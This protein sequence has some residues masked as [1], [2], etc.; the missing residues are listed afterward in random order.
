MKLV[1]TTITN[2]RADVIGKMLAAIAPHVDECIVIDTGADEATRINADVAVATAGGRITWRQ[3]RWR[4]DFAAARNHALTCAVAADADWVIQADTDEVYDFGNVAPRDFLAQAAAKGVDAV[5]V[6]H[7]SRMFGQ[8]RCLRVIPGKLPRWKMPVHEWLD[9][10]QVG[11]NAPDCWSWATQER[12]GEDLTAKYRHYGTILERYTREHPKEPRGW[13]YL[14]DCYS[15]LGMNASALGAWDRRLKL[16]QNPATAGFY[17]EIGWTAWRAATLRVQLG[18]LSEACLT[19]SRGLQHCPTMIELAWLRGFVAFRQ[20][21]FP[22]ALYWANHALAIPQENRHGGFA[23]PP[24]QRDYPRD[25]KMHAERALGLP[26]G[27]LTGQSLTRPQLRPIA[28]HNGAPV[29]I[30]TSGARRE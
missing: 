20:G 21:D 13:F 30:S 29:T 16:A 11:A 6:P 2:A 8:P 28:T 27:G 12:P 9:G 5:M 24:A 23:Y 7:S 4:D 3:W 15:I 26:G 1:S 25:L 17:W 18:K 19:L 10:I 14:G 22:Q